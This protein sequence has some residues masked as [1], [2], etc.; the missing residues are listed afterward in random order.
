LARPGEPWPV[1]ITPSGIRV[2]KPRVEIP[3]SKETVREF[4]WRPIQELQLRKRSTTELTT[5]GID[6][7]YDTLN[8][9]LAKHGIH[10]PFPSEEGA[11]NSYD[12]AKLYSR[13]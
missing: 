8:R 7:I 13:A 11:K 12:S 10:E 6:A 2:L 3:W 4:M 9:F 5:K 1:R